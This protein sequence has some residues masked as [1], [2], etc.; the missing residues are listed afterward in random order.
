[1]WNSVTHI[2]LF[3]F[4]EYSVSKYVFVSYNIEISAH[5][6]HKQNKKKLPIFCSVG[7]HFTFFGFLQVNK[8]KM[9]LR[10]R[11]VC[12]FLSSWPILLFFFFLGRWCWLS[13]WRGHVCMW[14]FIQA[15]FCCWGFTLGPVGADVYSLLFGS[16]AVWSSPVWSGVCGRCRKLTPSDATW[17]VIKKC[18]ICHTLS[19]LV[20]HLILEKN[21]IFKDVAGVC[22]LF[23]ASFG[24]SLSLGLSIFKWH[25]LELRT[26]V[27][28]LKGF[29]RLSMWI[30]VT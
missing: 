13:A 18:R 4:I 26:L 12:S 25:S 9:K 14:K 24:S 21:N 2:S 19:V 5:K 17:W 23:G 7:L 15:F 20:P 6:D 27:A 29:S 22:W 3:L 16:A 11:H 1:M 28:L 10:E 30:G 8:L